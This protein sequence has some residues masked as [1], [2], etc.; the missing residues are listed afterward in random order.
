MNE[1]RQA[2]NFCV[3]V[4]SISMME[5]SPTGRPQGTLGRVAGCD[6]T[7]ERQGAIEEVKEGI[8]GIAKLLDLGS[9]TAHD[10]TTL[11]LV[12]V[13][14]PFSFSTTHTS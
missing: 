1:R 8:C 3:R 6:P 9:C 10:N 2:R 5:A 14:G 13:C 12:V 4:Q 7:K 11:L